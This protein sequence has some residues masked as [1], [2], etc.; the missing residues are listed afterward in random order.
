MSFD[1]ERLERLLG[2]LASERETGRDLRGS[3]LQQLRVR[4]VLRPRG[5]FLWKGALAGSMLVAGWLGG[6]WL[7]ASREAVDL[8][9]LGRRSAEWIAPSD[10]IDVPR[11]MP[12]RL[13]PRMPS[14]P[15]M[16]VAPWPNT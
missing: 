7:S 16:A 10:A 5:G 11:A 4:G 3:V 8:G 2:L 13:L 6:E 1:H 14:A 12:V 15:S 9:E